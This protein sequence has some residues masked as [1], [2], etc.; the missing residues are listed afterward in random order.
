MGPTLIALCTDYVFADP[1]MVGSSIS[2]VCT[3]L[4]V[5]GTAVII[6]GL[7][8]FKKTVEEAAS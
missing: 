5:I 7:K 6:A 4:I 3:T 2:I 1:K 8:A